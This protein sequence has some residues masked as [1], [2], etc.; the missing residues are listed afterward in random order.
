MFTK[1]GTL[2]FIEGEMTCSI[3]GSGVIP[4]GSWLISGSLV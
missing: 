4:T 2:F 3:V 1:I